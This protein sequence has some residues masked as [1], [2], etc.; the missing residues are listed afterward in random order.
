MQLDAW[1]GKFFE[2][3]PAR[4]SRGAIHQIDGFVAFRR[5]RIFITACKIE[6]QARQRFVSRLE[7]RAFDMRIEIVVDRSAIDDPGN[8]IRFIVIVENIAVQRQRAVQQ[9][10]LRAQLERVDEFRLERQRMDRIGNI[11]IPIS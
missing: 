6:P 9:R 7:F 8:L 11:P 5:A 1:V 10:V 2:H 4:R 3:H